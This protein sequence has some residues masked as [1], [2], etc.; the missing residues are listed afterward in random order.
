MCEYCNGKYFSNINIF[1][2]IRIVERQISR[3]SKPK[4][5]LKFHNDYLE[6]KYCP[7]CGEKLN[8]D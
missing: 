3:I 4:K 6:I 7:M 5:C 2:N 1:S 8:S